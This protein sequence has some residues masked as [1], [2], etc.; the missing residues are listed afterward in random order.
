[1]MPAAKTS[2]TR[3][4]TLPYARP[5]PKAVAI[6]DLADDAEA[7]ARFPTTAAARKVRVRDESHIACPLTW[8]W[9]FVAK[10]SL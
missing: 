1:M 7:C 8:L 6:V 4:S 3:Q 2:P 5:V 9:R 10:A